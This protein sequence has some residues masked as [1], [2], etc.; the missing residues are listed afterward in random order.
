MFGLH[1][2]KGQ[3][4]RG[5]KL[6]VKHLPRWAISP[7]QR[8]I[9]LF[10]SEFPWQRSSRPLTLI[11]GVHGDEPEGVALAQATLKWLT[12]DDPGTLPWIVIPILNVD[13]YAKKTR[14]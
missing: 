7:G 12:T 11:G 10:H 3:E 2:G 1:W 6:P 5:D 9:E 14:V 4:T 13:G 8:P